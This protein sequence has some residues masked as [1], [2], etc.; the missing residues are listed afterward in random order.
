MPATESRTLPGK[1]ELDSIL[2]LV[3]P[4][5]HD[6]SRVLVSNAESSAARA[7]THA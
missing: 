1:S 4:D 5:S 7:K 3:G 6:L 2:S